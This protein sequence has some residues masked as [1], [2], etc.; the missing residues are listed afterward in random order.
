MPLYVNNNSLSAE[1][2]NMDVIFL[3]LMHHDFKT[4]K[5]IIT[6]HQI[7]EGFLN[8]NQFENTFLTFYA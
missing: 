1:I 2:K 6:Y 4:I 7:I 5:C 8:L 3:D